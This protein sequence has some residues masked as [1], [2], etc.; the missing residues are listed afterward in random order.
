MEESRKCL[1]YTLPIAIIFNWS[2][3]AKLT[4]YG[5][6]CLNDADSRKL[7][8]SFVIAI[9]FP[10]AF[11]L[12]DFV[13]LIFKNKNS[14]DIAG[15]LSFVFGVSLKYYSDD[16]NIF[17]LSILLCASWLFL[18]FLFGNYNLSDRGYQEMR[19]QAKARLHMK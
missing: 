16:M 9:F 10:L 6:W 4:V 2:R 18:V 13:P 5:Y 12:A 7:I 8:L 11:D 14:A 19:E 15:F 17:L 3:L 1:K